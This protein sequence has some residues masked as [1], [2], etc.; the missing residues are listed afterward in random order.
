M[1]IKPVKELSLAWIAEAEEN[2]KQTHAW[3][4]TEIA[5]AI[6]NAMK[7]AKP[8]K[9]KFDIRHEVPKKLLDDCKANDYQETKFIKT[10]RDLLKPMGYCFE[11]KKSHAVACNRSYYVL[12]VTC[13]LDT[14]P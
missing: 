4:N 12:Q 14:E 1:P 5:D 10:V 11:C 7:E 13:S 2:R 8:G 3:L 9:L 6:D